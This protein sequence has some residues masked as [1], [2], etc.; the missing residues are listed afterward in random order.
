MLRPGAKAEDEEGGSSRGRY[1]S[2]KEV[3]HSTSEYEAEILV[4]MGK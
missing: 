3:R 1:R 4:G 2:W